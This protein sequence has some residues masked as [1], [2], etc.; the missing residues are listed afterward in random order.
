M[1]PPRVLKIQ[2][3]FTEFMNK[4]WLRPRRSASSARLL[5]FF[6][7]DSHAGT[8]ALLF[9]HLF[10]PWSV[11]KF[12]TW[13]QEIQR[14]EQRYKR[15]KNKQRCKQIWLC[16]ESRVWAWGENSFPHAT[17]QTPSLSPLFSHASLPLNLVLICTP[18][19]SREHRFFS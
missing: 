7:H 18:F 14:N 13:C 8:R 2:M 19:L 6:L 9:S 16:K 12:S 3:C 4:P 15:N 5:L 11:L 1:L 10:F 17:T